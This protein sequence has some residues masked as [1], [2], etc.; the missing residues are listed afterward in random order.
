MVSS[1]TTNYGIEEM[2][3]GEKS[4]TWGT[5]TNFN[6]DIVDR[7]A[8][9]KSVALSGSTHTLT[10]REASPGS[11]TENLQD[12]MYRVIKFTGALGANNTVTIAPNTTAAFFI[13]INATTDSGSSG[14]Y[15]VILSQGS[16]ANITVPNGKTAVVYCDGAGSGA[17]VVDA[18]ANLYISDSIIIGDGTAEDTKIVFDGNAQDYYIGLD[19]SADDLV[20]GLGSAVGTTPAIS[21]DENQA[22]VVPSASLTIGDGTAEDT[23]LV[24][25]GNA[26]D[27]Y[28]GLDDSADDLVI[29][30]G[31]TVGTTPA[32]TI[33]EN[34]AVVL[35]AASVTIGDGTAE[36]TKLVYNGNAQDYYIGLDDSADDLV[37]GL[38][39][40]V[41]TTP[42]ISVDENQMT[43]FGKAALGATLT[44]TSNTGS[45]TLDFNAYQNFILTFT[46]NVTLANP[47]TES[48]GQTGVIVIIQDGT[49]SRTLTL[50]TDYET[51]AGGGLTISTTASAVDVLPYFVKASGSIQLGAPQLAFA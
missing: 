2:A 16:G 44:D 48:V 14:P 26:Q 5:I 45:V 8:A 51:P 37:I 28:I 32:I 29:G 4:G 1:F 41:G 50:G 34:Q 40:A 46:G 10:V 49:G 17:A 15:N 9:Y 12:G 39:S 21:I 43:T 35:P 13:I 20:I 23:K 30:L 19:D 22:V 24:Y 27:F 6:F 31:S 47:S 11:G 7:I 36:D 42:A 3:T 25:N 18:L 33:D 38:G